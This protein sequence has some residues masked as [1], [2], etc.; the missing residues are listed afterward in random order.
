[1][2][3]E[4]IAILDLMARVDGEQAFGHVDDPVDVE[5][6]FESMDEA[7]RVFEQTL[8]LRDALR[9]QSPAEDIPEEWLERINSFSDEATS[10]PKASLGAN[11]AQKFSGLVSSIQSSPYAWGGGFAT[12]CAF[13]IVVGQP[14]GDITLEGI[15]GQVTSQDP[16]AMFEALDGNFKNKTNLETEAREGTGSDDLNLSNLSTNTSHSGLTGNQVITETVDDC[17]FQEESEANE[18]ETMN[19]SEQPNCS[20]ASESP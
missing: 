2:D 16:R 15:G 11:I 1:M 13:V 4:K 7:E 9:V 8:T 5:L 10:P 17:A 6:G 19:G 20:G 14:S 12:A 3:K 18:S